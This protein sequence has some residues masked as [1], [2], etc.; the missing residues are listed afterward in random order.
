MME[1]VTQSCIAIRMGTSY[2]YFVIIPYRPELTYDDCP[3]L[4]N[5]D[6]HSIIHTQNNT[7]DRRLHELVTFFP[8]FLVNCRG[9]SGLVDC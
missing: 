7:K 6:L 9:R 2:V 3:A 8:C 4:D 1:I 5:C